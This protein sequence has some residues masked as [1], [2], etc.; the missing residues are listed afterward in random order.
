MRGARRPAARTRPGGTSPVG[1]DCRS[2]CS[3]A[4]PYP[5]NAFEASPP[6]SLIASAL[7]PPPLEIRFW[8]VSQSAFE[9]ALSG[10]VQAPTGFFEVVSNSLIVNGL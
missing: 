6:E 7:P 5:A 9:Q 3:P 8:T 10:F 2:G 4:E 1:C